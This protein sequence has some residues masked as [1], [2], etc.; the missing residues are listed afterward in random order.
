MK[1]IAGLIAAFV[2]VYTA[3]DIV[4]DVAREQKKDDEPEDAPQ[5]RVS[6]VVIYVE[7]DVDGPQPLTPVEVVKA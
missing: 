1:T 4:C 2:M 6:R 3:F 5:V 7:D